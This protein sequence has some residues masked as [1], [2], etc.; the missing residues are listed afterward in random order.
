MS[1]TK[2]QQAKLIKGLGKLAEAFVQG[3]IGKKKT[4]KDQVGNLNGTT[5][6]KEGCGVCGGKK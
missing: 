2:K 6:P 4:G 5:A 3:A 1:L